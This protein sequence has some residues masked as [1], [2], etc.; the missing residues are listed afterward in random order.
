MKHLS[1]VAFV[2]VILAQAFL[3]GTAHAKD[4]FFDSHWTLW[5]NADILIWT[6]D[7]DPAIDPKEFCLSLRRNNSGI[8]EPK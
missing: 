5:Q 6:P 4:V 1:L 8:G 7:K 3:A 2:A